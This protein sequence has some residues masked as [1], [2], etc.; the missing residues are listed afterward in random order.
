MGVVA[1][2]LVAKAKS[3]Y[4]AQ[5]KLDDYEELLHKRNVGEIAGYLKHDTRYAVAL[6][7]IRENNIHRGQLENILKKDLFYQ[8]KKLYKYAQESSKDFFRIP[9]EQIEMNLILKMVRRIIASDH[10]SIISELPTFLKSDIC[11]DIFKFASIETYDEL[12][13]LLKDTPYYETLLQYRKEK[14][15]ESEIDYTSC[16]MAMMNLYYDRVFTSIKAHFKGNQ[17]KELIDFYGSEIELANIV[18]IYRHKQ[19]FNSSME[20]IR[21]TLIPIYTHIREEEMEQMIAAA[22]MKAFGQLLKDCYYH[23]DIDLDGPVYIEGY[24]KKAR[25][26]IS[27]KNI[28]FSQNSPLIFVSYMYLQKTELENIT[29]VIEGVR[30]S[31]PEDDIRDMVIC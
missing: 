23:I 16:E 29:S 20:E 22:N 3:M 26:N 11:F 10:E 27:R 21:K 5:L 9:V 19:Y 24:L 18:K 12:L 15:H 2:A 7:D 25:F 30:Y 8:A 6:K 1:G 13:E 4:G 28:Y 17:R 31:L 14:G